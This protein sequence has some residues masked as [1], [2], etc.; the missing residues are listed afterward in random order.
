M[1][2]N[3]LN[4]HELERIKELFDEGFS[5]TTICM[6]CM[7]EK[8]IENTPHEKTVRKYLAEVGYW[9]VGTKRYRPLSWGED[10]SPELYIMKRGKDE[11]IFNSAKEARWYIWCESERFSALSETTMA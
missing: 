2:R 1:I 8:N 4:D 11:L 7:L 3:Q 5:L 9:P 6:G 10:G